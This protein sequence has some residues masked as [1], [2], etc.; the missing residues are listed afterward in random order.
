VAH[1]YL[2]ILTDLDEI[3]IVRA[4]LDAP[5]LCS[6]HYKKV[7]KKQKYTEKNVLIRGTWKWIRID[8]PKLV[9]R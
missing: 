7:G 6:A 9:C 2:D 5:V 8:E 3:L 4:V 1:K